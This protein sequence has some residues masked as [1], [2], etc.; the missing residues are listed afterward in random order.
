MRMLILLV[1]FI[2]ALSNANAQELDCLVSIEKMTPYKGAVGEIL[3]VEESPN[4]DPVLLDGE[5]THYDLSYLLPNGYV[6]HT[7]VVFHEAG[8]LRKGQKVFWAPASKGV[9][10]LHPDEDH[11]VFIV[12]GE[13]CEP[14]QIDWS[15]P[16]GDII[17]L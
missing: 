9:Q 5:G 13:G 1:V 17:G 7:W 15:L 14:F 12:M 3:V 2:G 8:L 6:G 10:E 16:A 11:K 4:T